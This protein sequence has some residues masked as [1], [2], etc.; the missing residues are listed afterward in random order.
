MM[1]TNLEMNYFFYI[2]MIVLLLVL[3][4]KN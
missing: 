2:I 1:I 4:H 3:A